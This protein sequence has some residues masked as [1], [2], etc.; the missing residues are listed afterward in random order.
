[1]LRLASL[2]Y[3]PLLGG[4]LVRALPADAL[5]ILHIL[6]LSSHPTL[7]PEQQFQLSPGRRLPL[8]AGSAAAGAAP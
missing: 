7:N 2:Q 1:M 5:R 3:L 6:P 8:A 4:Y